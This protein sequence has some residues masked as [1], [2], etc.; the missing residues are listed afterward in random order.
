MA[1]I[2]IFKRF[3]C[4]NYSFDPMFYPILLHY[5]IKNKI[6]EGDVR[7]FSQLTIIFIFFNFFNGKCLFYQQNIVIFVIY[8]SELVVIDTLLAK[9]TRNSK[10]CFFGGP[11][12]LSSSTRLA[13]T[14]KV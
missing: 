5:L 4:H 3:H 1:A 14:S 8:G 12:V 11:F 7:I 2:L 9:F 13:I 10:I 6:A